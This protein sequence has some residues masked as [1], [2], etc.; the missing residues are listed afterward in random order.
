MD[1]NSMLVVSWLAFGI[2]LFRSDFQEGY[3]QLLCVGCAALFIVSLA[4]IQANIDRL[5]LLFAVP[6]AAAFLFLFIDIARQGLLGQTRETCVWAISVLLAG[7]SAVVYTRTEAVC[8]SYPERA[9]QLWMGHGVFH[10]CVYGASVSGFALYCLLKKPK[11]VARA[12][13]EGI[14]FAV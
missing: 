7:T 14:N 11:D 2:V 13:V 8:D 4:C 3:T 6:N 5:P 12:V 9:N 10:L 1:T